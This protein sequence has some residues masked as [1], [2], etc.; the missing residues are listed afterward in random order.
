[1]LS[2]P[3]VLDVISLYSSLQMFKQAAAIDGSAK[4]GRHFLDALRRKSVALTAY[5][6]TLLQAD[7]R[8][9]GVDDFSKASPNR[10]HFTIITP[11]EPSRRGAQLSIL[12]SPANA[13]EAI[14]GRLQ[15]Q[16]VLADERKPGVIRLSPVPMYNTFVDVQRVA[17]ALS[18]AMG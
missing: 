14:F 13:M 1:M 10:L 17:L 15:E 3:S 11:R 4:S 12:F 18:H 9:L 2:N 8:Y 16:G 6:E 7:E 5:L